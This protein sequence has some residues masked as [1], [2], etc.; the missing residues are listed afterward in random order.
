[1]THRRMDMLGRLHT[2][3]VK[4]IDRQGVLFSEIMR[5][6]S[7]VILTVTID[8]PGNPDQDDDYRRGLEIVEDLEAF[9]KNETTLYGGVLPNDSPTN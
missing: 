2:V 7:E 1:M 5:L 8:E 9:L 4:L 3:T 6:I